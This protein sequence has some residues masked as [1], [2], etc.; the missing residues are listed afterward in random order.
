[1]EIQSQDKEWHYVDREI[2]RVIKVDA[3]ERKSDF[4]V[5]RDRNLEVLGI[6]VC[7]R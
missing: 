1:M 6:I 4:H 5:F 7:T 2:L 3:D